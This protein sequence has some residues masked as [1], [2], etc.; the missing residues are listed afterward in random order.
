MNKIAL[1]PIILL[2]CI[3]LPVAQA[4]SDYYVDLN[5]DDISGTGSFS[6][7]WA[8]I[9]KCLDNV[10]PGDNCSIRGGT[11]YESLVLKTSGAASD[12]ITIKKY[13]GET[14]TVDSSSLDSVVTGGRIH[15]Y[16]IDGLRFI[17]T[18]TPADQTD[19]TLSF[20]E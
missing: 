20:D 16:T 8:T 18:K 15:Y 1:I 3:L 9:Q 6:N 11:Y 14:V 4:A 17:S 12:R 2:V 19:S 10:Q 5:G 7:P 13:N